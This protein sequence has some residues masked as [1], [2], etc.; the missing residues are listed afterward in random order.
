[1]FC[2]SPLIELGCWRLLQKAVIAAVEEDFHC[3]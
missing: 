1:M 3:F 2:Y